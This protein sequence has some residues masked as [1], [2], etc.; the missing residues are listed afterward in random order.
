MEQELLSLSEHLSSP[1]VFSGVL[2]T[3]GIFKLFSL[4]TNFNVCIRQ[5]SGLSRLNYQRFSTLELYLM[6]SLYRIPVYSG[7][8]LDKFH[9]ITGII[10]E[11]L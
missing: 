2:V 8:N 4:G 11:M 10:F 3:L 5:V 7:F 9:C 6:F 1:L